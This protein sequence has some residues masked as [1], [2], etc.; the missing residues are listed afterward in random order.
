MGAFDAKV[1]VG[2]VVALLA[3]CSAIY[4]VQQHKIQSA[5]AER[6]A[7]N[8]EILKL[9]NSRSKPEAS[10]TEQ[11]SEDAR[12]E[13][14]EL[15][16]LRNKV[17]QLRRE[18]AKT[19]AEQTAATDPSAL[20]MLTGFTAGKYVAKQELAFAG[21]ATP[22][23]TLLSMTWAMLRGDYDRANEALSPENRAAEL[24]D[25]AEDPA[26]REKYEVA[27]K[28]IEPLFKGVQ[29]VARKSISADRV[30]LKVKV[31]QDPVPDGPAS[32]PI[33]IQ[34]MERYG[35][36]WKL[37]GSTREYTT[38]WDKSGEVQVLVSE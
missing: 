21:Y 2:F 33:S 27:R 9:Q 7:L 14:L 38:E 6:H 10:Q 12:K 16:R 18:T 3:A 1:A 26:L 31:V 30:E 36:E 15:M 22:E 4:F 17:A 13:T 11:E 8:A 23:A 5:N 35:N 19:N 29:L 32:S 37:S 24:K 34:P 20:D 28:T 25:Q